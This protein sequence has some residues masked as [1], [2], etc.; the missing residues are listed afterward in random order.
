M[1]RVT[2]VRQD[3]ASMVAVLESVSPLFAE[4]NQIGVTARPNSKDPL[5]DAVGWLPE[6][7]AEADYTVITQ[8]FRGTAIESLLKKLP[9]QYGRTRLIRMRPKS[10]LSIHVDSAL[11]YHFAITTNPGCYIVGLSDR[12]GTFHHIPADGRLY[13]MDGYRTHTAMNSGN[14]DRVHLVICPADQTRP[15]DAEP[16]GRI[17]VP[18]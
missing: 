11:R 17:S 13:E 10:C 6:G 12:E 3:L 4:H 1:I 8:P 14:Q 15:A 5:F 2:D 7:A 18:L 9:F 16:V